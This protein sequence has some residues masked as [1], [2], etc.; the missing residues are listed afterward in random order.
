ML[1]TLALSGTLLL[2]STGLSLGLPHAPS[3]AGKT[4]AL[5]T[6]PVAQHP[7]HGLAAKQLR[8]TIH[9]AHDGLFYINATVNGQPVRFI[10]DTGS[11]VVVL[12]KRDAARIGM[13]SSSAD[14]VALQ[15]VGGAA[16]MQRG[17]IDRL[18]VA[19]QSLENVDVATVASGLDVSL[20]G[21][22]ALAR[23]QSLRFEGDR[24][25]LN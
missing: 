9:R 6:P 19:G 17:S 25:E 22:S 5:T 23:L 16:P 15:T 3:A 20:L 21:Q 1:K 13:T 12:T 10:V 8:R 11:N 2:T 7:Q 14:T 18:V 4:F 24:L